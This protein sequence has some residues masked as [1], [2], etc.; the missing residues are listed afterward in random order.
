MPLHTSRHSLDEVIV[1][2]D[3]RALIGWDKV[4]IQVQLQPDVEV[5]SYSNM[6]MQLY[7]VC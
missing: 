4:V 1:S 6:Y 5:Y 7:Y 3:G 2:D